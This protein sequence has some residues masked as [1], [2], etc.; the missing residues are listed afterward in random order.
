M[1]EPIQSGLA[2][3]QLSAQNFFSFVRDSA[4]V[5]FF[6]QFKFRTSVGSELFHFISRT[7]GSF[8]MIVFSTLQLCHK[9]ILLLF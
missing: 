3:P 2:L 6:T 8:L 4:L 1:R 9:Q 5:S 7:T